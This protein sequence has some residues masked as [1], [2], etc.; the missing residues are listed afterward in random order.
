VV[1]HVGY[2]HWEWLGNGDIEAVT[3]NVEEGAIV[4][5][6]ILETVEVVIDAVN[7]AEP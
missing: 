1:R 4:A 3:V 6:A 5:E 7:G 2:L